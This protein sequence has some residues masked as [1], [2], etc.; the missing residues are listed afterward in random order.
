MFGRHRHH[1]HHH[2]GRHRRPPMRLRRRIFMWFGAAIMVSGIVAV[3]LGRWVSEGV[4]GQDWKRAERF[5]SGEVARV[6]AD[7][8]EREAFLDRVSSSFDVSIQLTDAQG[9]LIGTRGKPCTGKSWKLPVAEA[10]VVLGQARLCPNESRARDLALILPLLAAGALLWG[11]SGRIAHRLTRSLTKVVRVTQEIGEGKLDAR[12]HLDCRAPDEI[13]TL[14][15]AINDMAVRLERQLKEQ[16][17]L[18]AAVSHELRTPLG[19]LRILTDIAR[20]RGVTPKTLDEIEAEI[21]EIDEL[22]GQL[23]ARSRLDLTALSDTPVELGELARRAGER[24]GVPAEKVVVE[25]GPHALRGDPTLLLRALA[26]LVDNA[27][28]HGGGL[29]HLRVERQGEEVL[30]T[31]LDRGP[32][33]RPGEEQRVL[34]PFYGKQENGMLG[35]GLALVDRIARA[36]GGRA[37]AENREG[38]GAR[39]GLVLPLSREGADGAPAA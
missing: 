15:L 13:S 5:A 30:V 9:L 23:L 28:K 27:K 6:W 33:L 17:M 7:A 12:V 37:I 38:G 31:A 26:N 19:H 24:A 8:A 11:A 25:G 29:D 18:L 14:S 39:M 16:R 21:H 22:V 34:E 20:E 2:H 10:G 35:L 32:G 4:W 1:G 36:H 3:V